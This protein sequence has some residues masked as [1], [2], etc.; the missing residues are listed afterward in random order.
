MRVTQTQEVLIKLKIHIAG[1]IQ[2]SII[3]FAIALAL[4]AGAQTVTPIGVNQL[5]P[6]KQRFVN[7][8]ANWI[9]FSVSRGGNY[10]VLTLDYPQGSDVTLRTITAVTLMADDRR[11][12]LAV[13]RPGRAGGY[14][15]S[16]KWTADRSGTVYARISSHGKGTVY[17]V[18]VRSDQ[19]S[20]GEGPA[21]GGASQAK[22]E[23]NEQ[24][25]GEGAQAERTVWTDSSTGLMWAKGDNG[26]DVNW[27]GAI[28]Y[29]RTLSLGGYSGWRL[30]EMSE[31]QDI[32]DPSANV[33][34]VNPSRNGAPYHIKGGIVLSNRGIWSGTRNG[35]VD[36][37][38]FTFDTNERVPVPKTNSYYMR[39]LCVRRSGE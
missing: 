38:N 4:P 11:T 36:V 21:A 27:G 35:P 2:A 14:G 30:P 28:G 10:Q 8:A 16:L 5:P 33:Y 22:T 29:C 13:G 9:S 37:W 17:E 20:G 7:G 3:A 31:L 24:S 25:G 12:V 6:L 18:Q 1:C 15:V 19:Q 26:F 39:A 32:Y 23:G 34:G